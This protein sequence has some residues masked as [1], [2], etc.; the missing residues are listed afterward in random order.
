M[1]KQALIG[2]PSVSVS[3]HS[4]GHQGVADCSSFFEAGKNRSILSEDHLL[5]MLHMNCLFS[6]LL[7]RR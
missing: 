2:S 5:G 6:S 3:P 7:I 1:R 4:G